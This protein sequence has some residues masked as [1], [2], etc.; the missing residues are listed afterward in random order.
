MYHIDWGSGPVGAHIFLI[1][2]ISFLIICIFI[3]AISTESINFSNII[4]R[5]QK[6][7]NKS[8]TISKLKSIKPINKLDNERRISSKTNEVVLKIEK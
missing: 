3:M 1:I 4:F 5:G 2:F 8:E 6:I 7:D